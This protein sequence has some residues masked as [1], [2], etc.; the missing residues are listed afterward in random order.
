[1]VAKQNTEMHQLFFFQTEKVTLE[2]VSIHSDEE[3]ETTQEININTIENTQRVHNVPNRN[4]L[5][6]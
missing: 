1:M 6:T 3:P 5:L 4:T 2:T